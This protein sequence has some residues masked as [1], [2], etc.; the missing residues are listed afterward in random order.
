M[1]SEQQGRRL[2]SWKEIADYLGR[3]VRTVIRWEKERGLPVRRLPGGKRQSVFAF[4]SEIDAW[5]QRQD[6]VSE[7]SAS[8]SGIPDTGLAPAA[9]SE[10]ASN[11]PK[12]R[13]F[14]VAIG[15]GALALLVFL[16]W[17][18]TARVDRQ[19]NG[20]SVA[21]TPN[22][23]RFD[24]PTG[25]LRFVRSELETGVNAYRLAT[26]DF[27][28]DGALD[29]AFT[30]SPSDVVG[31]LLGRGDGS[32]LPAQLYERCAQSD[33]IVVA[34]FNRDGHPDIAAT[35]IAANLLV[36]LWGKGDG[37]FPTRTEVPVPG[38]P[39]FPAVGDLNKDGWP[40]LVVSS[41]G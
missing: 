2:D 10:T 14:F 40:D 18:F 15:A 23:I 8:R 26:G 28:H 1:A 38:G 30:A 39:R 21:V 6:N 12:P 41:V 33:S 34:D 31:V 32:F 17:F 25:S 11:S 22:E 19:T 20:S 24:L 37:T 35:C 3:D 7:V 16:G 5:L 9:T 13:S 36:V 29:V 4:A 27:N